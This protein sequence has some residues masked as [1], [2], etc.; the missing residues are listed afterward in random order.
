LKYLRHEIVASPFK[1]M[2]KSF[3]PWSMVALAPVALLIASGCEGDRS[4]NPQSPEDLVIANAYT[5]QRAV[6]AFARENDGEYPRD[7]TEESKAGNTLI[8]LLPAGKRLMNPYTFERSVPS[9]Y[10]ALK[11][12]DVGYW[13]CED[14]GG[15]LVG[16]A[17]NGVGESSEIIVLSRGVPDSILARELATLANC[18]LVRDAVEAFAAENNGVYPYD[19]NSD[20]TAM[21]NTVMDLLGG[22][23]LINPF[24]GYP[25]VPLAS[26]AASN[27]G[28]TGYYPSGMTV[29]D[30]YL[31]SGYGA[32]GYVVQAARD[33]SCSTI[34]CVW[35]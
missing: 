8:D 27:P 30:G 22:A 2:R 15:G 4:N 12:G 35:P 5:I 20:V 16:Y 7:S 3:R 25:D 23:F 26:G 17:I 11:P 13:P 14:A 24:T 9:F 34:P 21:G 1:R 28:E 10:G 33:P 18:R 31:L 6:E 29:P 19:T 32:T